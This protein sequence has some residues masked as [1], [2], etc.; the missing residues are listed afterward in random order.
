MRR[1]IHI[2]AVLAATLFLP[3]AGA[4][5]HEPPVQK[6]LRERFGEWADH[7]A[8]S[9]P[10]Y[11]AVEV[12]RQSRFDRKGRPK[13]EREFTF[14]YSLRRSAET[15]ELVESREPVDE[16]GAKP[17]RTIGYFAK[18]PLL[19]TRL[20]TRY[21]EQM[22]YF[23]EPEHPDV[24]SDLVVVGYRQRDGTGLME[25]DGKP[26]MVTGRAWIDPDDGKVSRIEEE[27]GNTKERY[28]VAVD[29]AADSVTQAWL[30]VYVT[31]RLV[32]KGHVELQNHYSYSNFTLA[33]TARVAPAAN[34]PGG[35]TP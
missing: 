17:D 19:V 3:V 21:H 32:E 27:F 26:V 35:S 22:K 33:G 6:E 10:S 2:A 23:F 18:L 24:S 15:H 28:W 34:T 25:L 9:L 11:Q 16:A 30:P 14:R 20:A 31:V 12:V 7:Y 29:F 1:G 5:Q 13:N 8:A 4:A